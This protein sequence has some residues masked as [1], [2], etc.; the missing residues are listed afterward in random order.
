VDIFREQ[1]PGE[2]DLYTWWSFWGGARERNVGWRIDYTCVSPGLKE[3]C[4]TAFIQP[5]VMGS[6][7]CPVGLLLE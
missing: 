1:H 7:H 3:R 2:K 6:D 4:Q 5:E